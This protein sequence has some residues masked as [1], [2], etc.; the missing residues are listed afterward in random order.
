MSEMEQANLSAGPPFSGEAP[1]LPTLPE[2]W[3]QG[4]TVHSDGEEGDEEEEEEETS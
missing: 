4:F 3:V 2:G 1:R